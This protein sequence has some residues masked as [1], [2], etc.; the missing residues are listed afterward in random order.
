MSILD[1]FRTAN[2]VSN[3]PKIDS[4]VPGPADDAGQETERTVV[5]E[6]DIQ[7]A[8]SL[9]TKYKEGKSQLERR[10]IEEE[11]FYKLMHWEYVNGKYQEAIRRGEAPKPASAWLVNSIINKHA[12]AMDNFP[13]PLV[14]PRERSDE[15]SAKSLTEILPV[16]MDRTK[17]K[18]TYSLIWWDKLKH[19]TGVYGVFWDKTAENG[20]GDVAIR[21]IDLLNIFWEPGITDIQDSRNLFIVKLIDD[22]IVADM[23][24][25]KKPTGKPITVSEYVTD[26]TIDTT[27]KSLLVDWYYKKRVGTRTVLHYVQFCGND[28]LYASEND[29]KCRE[30]GFYDHGKYPVVFDVLYPE[31]GTPA[32]FGIVALCKDPQLY[33]DQLDSNILEN[34]LQGTKRRWFVSTSLGI[35]KEQFKDWNEPFVDVEGMLDDSRIQELVPYPLQSIYSNI[36]EAKIAEM[37]ETSSNRDV[38]NGGSGSTN[39]AS[40]IAALQEAGNKVSRDM[41][42]MTYEADAEINELVIELI[43]QFYDL[44]RAFRI[45]Q[46]NGTAEYIEM[47]NRGLVD[48]PAG[49]TAIGE[50]MFRKPVFDLKLRAQKSNPFSRAEE[51]ERAMNLYQLGFFN[52]QRADEAMIALDMMDFEGIEKVK[53]KIAQNQQLLQMIQQMSAMLAQLTGIGAGAQPGQAQPA[54]QG[55]VDNTIGRNQ[56][57]AQTPNRTAMMNRLAATAKPDMTMTSRAATPGKKA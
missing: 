49:V 50:Q 39:T 45:M 41:L 25:E 43:R 7:E 1:K 21:Q 35:N 19:G 24:P 12:D 32:G 53:E 51:N 2:T 27:H 57:Q 29:P 20:L 16:L 15:D 55:S 36:R 8:I 11:Q 37:K 17:F 14:L 56:A 30:R 3:P 44:P 40:G 13:E 28:I 48:Q 6:K 33:I 18:R 46:P 47:S 10:V 22:D 9:L 54:Q 31:K 42:S 4:S 52:A 34:S 5:G 23:L 26:D 38:N